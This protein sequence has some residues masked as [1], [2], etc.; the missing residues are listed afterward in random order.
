[1]LT[2]VI[3]WTSFNAWAWHRS[4]ISV[5]RDTFLPFGVYLGSFRRFLNMPS[6]H[7]GMSYSG[8]KRN[9]SFI[10]IVWF[11]RFWRKKTAMMMILWIDFTRAVMFEHGFTC[12]RESAPEDKSAP[13]SAKWCVS[14][15]LAIS[16]SKIV[17]FDHWKSAKWINSSK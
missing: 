13:T 12:E 2:S 11:M 1:M 6:Y 4:A 7:F 3:L 10:W 5:D 8:S 16:W 15:S 14:L 9:W 17:L